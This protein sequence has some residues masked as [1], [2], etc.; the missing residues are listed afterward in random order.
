[1]PFLCYSLSL[2][3]SVLVSG[4]VPNSPIATIQTMI[5]QKQE[6]QFLAR[7]QV[8]HHLKRSLI[9]NRG[10]VVKQVIV[11]MEAKGEFEE[12][13]SFESL[14]DPHYV[15][16]H[17]GMKIIVVIGSQGICLVSH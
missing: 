11:R 8:P 9:R 17:F 3:L 14:E 4:I 10:V 15:H 7:N 13:Y 2:L 5:P 12:L 1:M 16:F 6:N